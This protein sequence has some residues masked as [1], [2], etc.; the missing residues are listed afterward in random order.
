MRAERRE[1]DVVA[2]RVGE[3]Q[4]LGLAV[5]GDQRD[6]EAA[7]GAGGGDFDRAAVEADGAGGAAGAG[8]EEGLEDLGAAGAEEAADAEDLAL[9]EVEVDAVQDAAPAVAAGDV[10]GEVADGE[11]DRRRSPGRSAGGAAVSRPT[12]AAMRRVRVISAIGAVRTW[13][14]SRSTVTR[15]ARS[16]TSSMRWEM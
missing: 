11:D 12:M 2:D 4:A 13:R 8:A 3:E 5:L 9:V 16:I 14:P 7:G 15:S 10:Q 6:A 1:R